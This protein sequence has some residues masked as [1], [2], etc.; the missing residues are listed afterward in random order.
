MEK[1]F[2]VNHPTGIHARPASRIVEAA[3]RYSCDIHLIKNGVRY[4]ARSLVK[5]I[6]IGAGFGDDIVVSAEGNQAPS[7]IE[8]IGAILTGFR[9]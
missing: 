6:A 1:T 3:A 2:T 4:N 7:A 5:M 8:A 9:S